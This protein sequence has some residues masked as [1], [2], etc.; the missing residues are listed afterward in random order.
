MRDPETL[1]AYRKRYT[2]GLFGTGKETV[3]MGVVEADTASQARAQII[4]RCSVLSLDEGV[5]LEI[6]P[7]D[8]DTCHRFLAKYD[9]PP[10]DEHRATDAKLQVTAL[11]ADFK[12]VLP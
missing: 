6:A 5:T 8:F 10:M 11:A 1:F 4:S 9:G 12:P 2:A 7:L 3:E